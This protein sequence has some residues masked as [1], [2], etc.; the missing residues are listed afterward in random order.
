MCLWASLT[1][2]TGSLLQGCSSPLV[3]KF[4][5][6]QR[7]KEQRRLQQQLVQQ[8]QQLNSTS[9]WGNLAGLGT[10]T[11]QYLAVSIN[12]QHCWAVT[13]V[14]QCD[15]GL[16]NSIQFN[17]TRC[18]NILWN[19]RYHIPYLNFFF[20]FQ[21][22]LQQATS[23]SNQGNFNSIQ[24]LGGKF[25]FFFSHVKT[26]VLGHFLVN[27]QPTL[28]MPLT[29]WLTVHPHGHIF[30]IRG[31]LVISAVILGFCSSLKD[32]PAAHHCDLV[33]LNISV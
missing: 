15:T 16:F 9:I 2:F 5:D 17:P 33:N 29:L 10:L 30:Q 25:V 32:K 26:I 3:V 24:R 4:A 14:F 27:E 6:T 31:M 20:V 18:R 19:Q 7:D 11:P 12:T 8:I 28:F 1:S 13:R 22:L 23:A 21:Q